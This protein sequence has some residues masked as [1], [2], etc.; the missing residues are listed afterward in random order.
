MWTSCIAIWSWNGAFDFLPLKQRNQVG[1]WNFFLRKSICI[2]TSLVNACNKP[3]HRH[4]SLLS[5]LDAFLFLFFYTCHY[6]TVAVISGV[7]LLVSEC[8]PLCDQVC[9]HNVLVPGSKRRRSHLTQAS[10][11]VQVPQLCHLTSRLIRTFPALFH[12]THVSAAMRHFYLFPY[13]PGSAEFC[14]LS[15]LGLHALG[16]VKV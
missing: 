12:I 6:L 5:G 15:A 10:S 11:L 8:H 16:T 7:F 14:V 3:S 13:D 2:P 4:S 1:G 9:G